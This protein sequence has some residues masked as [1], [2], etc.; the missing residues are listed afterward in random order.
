MILRSDLFAVS[1]ITKHVTQQILEEESGAGRT[2]NDAQISDHLLDSGIR[3]ARR[4]VAMYRGKMHILPS[5]VRSLASM[6]CSSWRPPD[7]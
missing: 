4:T 6:Q 2:P 5:T 3:I 7:A 1:L